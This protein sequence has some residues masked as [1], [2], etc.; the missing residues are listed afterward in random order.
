MN[1]GREFSLYQR[2]RR[3]GRATYPVSV[4][5]DICAKLGSAVEIG[6]TKV[7]QTHATGVVDENISLDY[8]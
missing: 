2:G 1:I 7:C 4:I 8:F 5:E 6:E 3:N